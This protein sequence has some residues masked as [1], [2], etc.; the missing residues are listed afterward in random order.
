MSSAFF[1]I[2]QNL[3]K[4]R[5]YR[6]Y[7]SIA[8]GEML[9]IVI[10]ILLALQID[11]WNQLRQ[12]NKIIEAYLEKIS[13][14]IQT[15]IQSIEGMLTDRK[16]SLIYTDSVLAY[17]NQGYI[18]DSKLF[19]KGYFGLFIETK[20]QPN[21]SAYESLKNSGF[22]KD[23]ENLKIEEQLNKYY[24]LIEN[25]S[26]VEN[27]FNGVTQPV[28]ISLLEKGFYTEFKEIFTWEHIDTVVFTIQ[29]MEKYPEYEGTFITAKMF[30][31]ELIEDY[32]AILEKGKDIIE[33]ID[34]GD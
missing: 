25:V 3:I 20:F 16:Q 11:N 28:E 6:E 17:Y 26:F 29:S 23:L 14:D 27:K 2:R 10:G 9:L 4:E 19:E 24:H 5:K 8:V 32:Q 18:T 13:N 7:V 21:I 1:R 15:D 22:M 30:L 12:E 33:L 34:N 31:E